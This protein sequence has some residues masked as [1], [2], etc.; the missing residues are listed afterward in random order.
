[1]PLHGGHSFTV[2]L[3]DNVDG[4]LVSNLDNKPILPWL[5]FQEAVCVLIRGGGRA[6]RENAMNSRFGQDDLSVD[7]VEGH[8]AQVVYGY[9]PGQYVFRRIAPVAAV[10]VW[11]GICTY[12]PGE[13]ILNDLPE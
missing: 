8:I 10:L 11:A 12:A 5:V 13:L 7:S 6:R 4:I 1:L 3:T 2:R 9:K